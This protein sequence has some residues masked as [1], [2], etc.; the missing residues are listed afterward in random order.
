MPSL[1]SG[2]DWE[3]F[4]RRVWNTGQPRD[5]ILLRPTAQDCAGLV[6]YDYGV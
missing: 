2:H 4:L 3:D 1:R 6:F 5:F